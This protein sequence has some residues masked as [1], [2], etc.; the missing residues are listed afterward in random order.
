MNQVDVIV[1]QAIIGGVLAGLCHRVG[2]E[3]GRAEG[4]TNGWHAGQEQGYFV[5]GPN[6]DPVIV[7]APLI[8]Y[9][10]PP[11]CDAGNCYCENPRTCQWH[12]QTR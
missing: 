12:R 7:R 5:V 2:L 8:I 10:S 6:D 9:E 11:E 3:K 1:I 4:W